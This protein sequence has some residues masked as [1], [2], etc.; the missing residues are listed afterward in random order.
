[1]LH[2]LK[3]MTRHC[4]QI[5]FVDLVELKTLHDSW[6]QACYL[7]G[8]YNFWLIIS[9]FHNVMTNRYFSIT[10]FSIESFLMH[11][12][13]HN[14]H[15]LVSLLRTLHN[16]LKSNVTTLRHIVVDNTNNEGKATDGYPSSHA[17]QVSRQS[18]SFLPK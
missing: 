5:E 12:N 18:P 14:K 6:P 1:M 9:T 7:F 3:T 15:S 10:L 16:I 4:C 2:G 11:G 8:Y 17:N 13:W